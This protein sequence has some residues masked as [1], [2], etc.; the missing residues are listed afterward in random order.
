MY[1]WCGCHISFFFEFFLPCSIV[2]L[3]P[4]CCV[5]GGVLTILWL[6]F[7]FR[8]NEIN[9]GQT[10]EVGLRNWLAQLF[11]NSNFNVHIYFT[12]FPWYLLVLD[13]LNC[14]S[15][16]PSTLKFMNHSQSRHNEKFS[17]SNPPF[18]GKPLKIHCPFANSFTIKTTLIFL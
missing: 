2:H 7:V 3:M 13:C 12:N 8:R 1:F 4:I 15:N 11:F 6:M 17:C 16:S 18:N 14:F 5:V 9:H 10:I